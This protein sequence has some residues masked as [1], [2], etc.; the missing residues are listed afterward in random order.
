[1]VYAQHGTDGSIVTFARRYDNF[2][3][4]DWVA[5]HPLHR[6]QGAAPSIRRG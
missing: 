5:P 6:A 4:G 3:G 1:M 2:I